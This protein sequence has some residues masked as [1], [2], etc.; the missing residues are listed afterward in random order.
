MDLW[1]I[2]IV[3]LLLVKSISRASLPLIASGIK[4][5][6]RLLQDFHTGQ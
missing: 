6:K 2:F 4:A 5:V 3:I 1:E